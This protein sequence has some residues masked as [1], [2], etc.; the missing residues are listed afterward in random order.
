MQ[1]RLKKPIFPKRMKNYHNYGPPEHK[2]ELVSKTHQEYLSNPDE[3]IEISNKISQYFPQPISDTRLVL[4][5]IDPY[6]VHAYWNVDE[7]DLA[8]IQKRLGKSLKDAQLVLRMYDIS[9][10]HYDGTNAHSHFDIEIQGLRNNWYIDLWSSAKSYC[11]DLGFR[12][13]RGDFHAIAHSNIIHIPRDSQSP[14]F[15]K[16]GLLVAEYPEDIQKLDDLTGPIEVHSE[17]ISTPSMSM[18]ADECEE[19]VRNYYEKLLGLNEKKPH[20][21]SRAKAVETPMEILH[22]EQAAPDL[23]EKEYT[24]LGFQELFFEEKGHREEMQKLH[25]LQPPEAQGK[26]ASTPSM[27]MPTKVSPDLAEKEYTPPGFQ[28]LFFEEKG[29][30]KDIQKLDSLQAPPEIQGKEFSPPSIDTPTNE[31]IEAIEN[32]YEKILGLDEKDQEVE[33]KT[34]DEVEKQH[35]LKEVEAEIYIRGRAEPGTTINLGGQPITV[36]SDGTFSIRHPLS[37]QAVNSLLGTSLNGQ[38]NNE[39]SKCETKNTKPQR[40]D[41]K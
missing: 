3:L 41:Q 34:E 38:Q 37:H 27:D 22:K 31:C 40:R 16:K 4:M 29:Q 17:E 19:A 24:P 32:Y 21:E 23:A 2:T 39:N 11:A 33:D 9:Y 14:L 8:Y 6:K 7:S 35:T 10:I 18:P 1:I 12:L 36:G 28:E 30:H 25:S 13:P 20:I 26:E 5:E 15:E